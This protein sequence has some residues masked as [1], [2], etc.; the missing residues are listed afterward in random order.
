MSPRL[1]LVALLAVF[2][3][4]GAA[5]AV[6]GQ[7]VNRSALRT[8]FAEAPAPA[9]GPN[10]AYALGSNR[11]FADADFDFGGYACTNQNQSPAVS[12]SEN[13]SFNLFGYRCSYG[14]RS[15]A[16]AGGWAFIMVDLSTPTSSMTLASS[17]GASGIAAILPAVN[18]RTETFTVG[19]MQVGF[20]TLTIRPA[21]TF[22]VDPATRFE[23][24]GRSRSANLVIATGVETTFAYSQR[25]F[26]FGLPV[27]ATLSG[28]A[29]DVFVNGF[30][31]A[32]NSA[33]SAAVRGNYSLR[34]DGSNLAF[35]VTFAAL[36]ITNINWSRPSGSLPGVAF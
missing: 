20:A 8:R 32:S 17:V 1:S 29:Q 25:V 13:T 16:S 22:R 11:Y 26:S 9:L 10:V 15:L 35:R 18:P 3:A 5:P 12:Y 34:D 27:E 23:A 4:A 7:C 14:M 28:K 36:P 30:T 21:V 6:H 19:T 24:V 33:T 31:Q 2:L